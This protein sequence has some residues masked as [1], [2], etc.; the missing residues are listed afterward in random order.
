MGTI[1]NVKII[2]NPRYFFWRRWAFFIMLLPFSAVLA[3][4][5][6]MARIPVL[7]L[8]LVVSGIAVQ[9][10]LNKR[11]KF[12]QGESKLTMDEH[13]LRVQHKGRPDEVIALESVDDIQ[14]PDHPQVFFD[15]ISEIGREIIS[16]KKPIALT[17]TQAGHTLHFFL[18]LESYYQIEKLKQLRAHFIINNS[19]EVIST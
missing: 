1:L 5:L 6:F 3:A 2:E 17:I 11:M 4:E 15:T 7:G 13:V 8:A 14:F 16:R 19:A 10:Y 12:W 18:L 9:Y